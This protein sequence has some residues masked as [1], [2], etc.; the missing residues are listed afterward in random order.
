MLLGQIG[1][2]ESEG[3]QIG[4]CSGMSLQMIFFNCAH[5]HLPMCDRVALVMGLALY[6]PGFCKES[7]WYVSVLYEPLALLL[8]QH[9]NTESSIL[10]FA[11][12]LFIYVK[13]FTVLVYLHVYMWSLCPSPPKK[14]TQHV[15]LQANT[16]THTSK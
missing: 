4:I 9:W 11:L 5:Q 10:C 1:T 6:L 7:L 15:S 13:R 12:Y 16:H 3:K 2:R 8:C 14:G